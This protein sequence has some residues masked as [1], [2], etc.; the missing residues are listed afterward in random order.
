M[1]SDGENTHL[2][3]CVDEVSEQCDICRASDKAPHVPTAG[4]ATV[5]MSKS[6]LQ[7]GLLFLGDL[8]A[9]RATGVPT[10]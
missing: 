2:V 10:T 9:L 3:D 6:K 4:A 1:D 5:K 8:I 7:V